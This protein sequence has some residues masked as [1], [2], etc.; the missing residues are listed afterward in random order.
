MRVHSGPIATTD[1]FYERDRTRVGGW[2]D[3]GALAV[4]MEA[5][6]LLQ[7]GRLREIEVACLLAVSDVFGDGGERRRIDTDALLRAA[8]RLGR[9]GAGAL[10]PTSDA[11]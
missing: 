2:H 9:A 7:V 10:S 8:E 11:G 6:A 3:A 1:L 4:E 5:A